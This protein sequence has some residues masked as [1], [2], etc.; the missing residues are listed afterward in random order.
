MTTYSEDELKSLLQKTGDGIAAV[1]EQ[2]LRGNWRDD[3]G[4]RVT[5]NTAMVNMTE[6]MKSIMD[7]RHIHLNYTPPK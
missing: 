6:V 3:F 2:M 5:N 1:F 4:N 7:F